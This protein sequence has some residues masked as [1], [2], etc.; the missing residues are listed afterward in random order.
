[1]IL[2]ALREAVDSLGGVI[3]MRLPATLVLARRP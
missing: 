3:H 1:M 2:A